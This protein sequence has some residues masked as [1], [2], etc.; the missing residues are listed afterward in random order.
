MNSDVADALWTQIEPDVYITRDQFMRGLAE[1]DVEPVEINGELAF[2]GLTKGPEFHFAS[3][4][5]GAPITLAMIRTRLGAIMDRHGYVTTRTPKEGADRQHRFN[6]AFGFQVAGE[7]E[8]F[9]H[10]RKD[11]KPCP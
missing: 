4:E 9:V 10:Y 7:D 11:D 6:Q 2:A 1:W 3:F 8:F 5:T